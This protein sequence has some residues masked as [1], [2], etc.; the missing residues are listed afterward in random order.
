MLLAP[1]RYLLS[2]ACRAHSGHLGGHA[3]A[4]EWKCPEQAWAALRNGWF[5][6]ALWV[7][8][9]SLRLGHLS[10]SCEPNSF[11]PLASHPGTWEW[12]SGKQNQPPA[13]LSLST[14]KD[15][16]PFWGA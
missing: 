8:L 12:R 10:L 13:G 14:P 11:L 6:W 15:W 2:A 5:P 16:L 7:A 1:L 4:L 3:L 9:H